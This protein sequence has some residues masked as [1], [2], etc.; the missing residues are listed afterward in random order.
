MTTPPES[1][2]NEPA[3]SAEKR[4]QQRDALRDLVALATE[5]AT[6]EAQIDRKLQSTLEDATKELEKSKWAIEQRFNSAQDA[7]KTE[8]QTRVN[9]AKA[10]YKAA[11][12]KLEEE[13]E[14]VRRRI[15]SANDPV[16]RKLK[17]KLQQAVWEADS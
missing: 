17:E 10:S 1:A 2:P 15:D 5:C 9:H 4:D 14:G 8:Y 16:E 12:V 6:T 13:D 11:M 3:T 7:G